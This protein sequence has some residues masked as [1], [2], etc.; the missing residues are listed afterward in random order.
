MTINITPTQVKIWKDEIKQQESVIATR[1]RNLLDIHQQQT[2][3]HVTE[4]LTTEELNNTRS[5]CK[6]SSPTTTI[7][8]N[9][10]DSNPQSP[11]LLC[12]NLYNDFR[13]NQ[14]QQVAFLILANAWLKL[15]I[16]QKS[17]ECSSLSNDK[18]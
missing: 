4:T 14:M 1:Q 6:D 9:V 11:F 17:Q 13:L 7:Q 3:T 2:L 10:F 5:F 15:Y 12:M 16:E 8:S 18:M